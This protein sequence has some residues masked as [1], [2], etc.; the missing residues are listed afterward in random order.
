MTTERDIKNQIAYAEEK[1]HEKGREEGLEKG[2]EEGA[3]EKAME[4][5]RAFLKLGIPPETVSVGTGLSIEEVLA[6][7]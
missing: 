3:R 4:T 6:L 7:V 2:R 5:A 1:G